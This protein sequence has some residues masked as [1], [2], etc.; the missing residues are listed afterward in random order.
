MVESSLRLYFMLSPEVVLA[1]DGE[2]ASD[3]TDDATDSSFCPVVVEA[4]EEVGSSLVDEFD[5]CSFV[6]AL[7]GPLVDLSVANLEAVESLD[8]AGDE[9]WE[10]LVE[11][12][13]A[14]L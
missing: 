7:D 13:M 10:L 6:P 4:D 12:S 8:V 1:P 11:L 2:T 9:S 14:L 3:V 5:S